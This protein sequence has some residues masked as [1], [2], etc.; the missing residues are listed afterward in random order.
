MIIFNAITEP[1][2]EPCA[3]EADAGR[4]WANTGVIRKNS[5][6]Q[7]LCAATSNRK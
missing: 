6:G 1:N 2:Y 4:Q 3:T 5:A 7:Y